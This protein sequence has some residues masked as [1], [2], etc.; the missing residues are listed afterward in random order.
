[1][2]TFSFAFDFPYLMGFERVLEDSENEE[3]K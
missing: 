2:K 3:I 1:M